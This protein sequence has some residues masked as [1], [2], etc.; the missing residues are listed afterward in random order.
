MSVRM[1]PHMIGSCS[2]HRKEWLHPLVDPKAVGSNR[3]AEIK[4]LLEGMGQ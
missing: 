3:T 1:F 2:V 4:T